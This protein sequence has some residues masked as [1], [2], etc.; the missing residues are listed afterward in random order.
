M[1]SLLDAEAARIN[2][3]SFIEN[4]PV[5]FPRRFTEQRDIE[6]TALLAA[7]IA[8]GNRKM[9]CKDAD[10]MLSMMA[11][12]PANFIMEGAFESIPDEINIHRTFF[13]RNL[14]HWAR[15]LKKI[16]K[17]HGT[18]EAFASREGVAECEM[19]AWKLAV[20]LNR[21]LALANKGVNDPRCLPVNVDS[22]AL[23]RLNMALRW[24]V[25][26]DGIVDIGIW[27]VLKPSQL[28]IPLDVHVGR[29]SREIGLLQRKST[30]AKAA[31]EL[32]EACRLM[33]PD[34]PAVYDFSLFGIGMG[35]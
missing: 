28:F 6:T 5:Q 35:L 25:R 18:I 10:K 26:D 15:G 27:K 7:T 9:I 33:N 31:V 12:D 17:E 16:F 11:D 24:L 21:E 19:P 8:W 4:D 3:K 32:T 23:K 29:V 34:D 20:A 30:D 1:K 13:G 2:H 22:S 14:K